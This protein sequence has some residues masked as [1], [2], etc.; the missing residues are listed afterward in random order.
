MELVYS[1]RAC[2]GFGVRCCTDG[3]A[4]RDFQNGGFEDRPR[5]CEEYLCMAEY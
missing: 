3:D 1:I 5:T 4:L 2:R